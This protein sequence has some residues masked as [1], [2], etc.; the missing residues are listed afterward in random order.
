MSELSIKEP[1]E[2]EI[3]EQ[4]ERLAK[5]AAEQP[6]FVKAVGKLARITLNP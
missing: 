2:Q 3:A 5:L 1:S 6:S 4:R